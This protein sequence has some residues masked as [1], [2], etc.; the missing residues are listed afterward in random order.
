MSPSSKITLHSVSDQLAQSVLLTRSYEFDVLTF[1]QIFLKVANG[2]LAKLGVLVHV[3]GHPR[4][5]IELK[6]MV[7]FGQL[8][9]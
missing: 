8:H 6:H 1:S 7:D 2:P 3:G 4:R 9:T 5:L